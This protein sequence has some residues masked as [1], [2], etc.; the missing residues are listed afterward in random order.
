MN[1]FMQKEEVTPQN[2]SCGGS[3]FPPCFLLYFSWFLTSTQK[4]WQDQLGEVNSRFSAHAIKQGQILKSRED[5]L[6]RTENFNVL[7]FLLYQ[8]L[9][10]SVSDPTRRIGS[11][12]N[13]VSGSGFRQAKITQK[14]LYKNFVLLVA[15]DLLKYLSFYYNP[16]LG[17]NCWNFRTIYGARNR[18]GIGLYSRPARHIG[19]R[20]RFLGSLKVVIYRF[21]YL[22]SWKDRA[23]NE[24]AW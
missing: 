15:G 5:S 22:Q 7:R 3:S 20:N 23:F 2:T 6:F 19:W 1:K 8:S 17:W 10:C 4:N 11:G 13:C 21:W 16:Q 14:K 18:V 24:P 9:C 12:F